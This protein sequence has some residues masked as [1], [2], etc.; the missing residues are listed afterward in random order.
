M[1]ASP[2]NDFRREY[3]SSNPHRETRSRSGNRPPYALLADGRS[4]RRFPAGL[5]SL[6]FRIPFASVGKRGRQCFGRMRFEVH[7]QLDDQSH[8]TGSAF[9]GCGEFWQ[10]ATLPISRRVRPLRDRRSGFLR[11]NKRAGHPRKHKRAFVCANLPHEKIKLPGR[12]ALTR[13]PNETV[14]H[15]QNRH[16][17]VGRAGNSL[18]ARQGGIAAH[19][20]WH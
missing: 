14:T 1:I 2:Q 15:I 7:V 18:S 4:L 6:N 5:S 19:L 9:P 17:S 12:S 16:G 8:G 10:E 11:I 13:K 3:C 20:H